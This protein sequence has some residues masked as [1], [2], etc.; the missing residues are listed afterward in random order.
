MKIRGFVFWPWMYE[1]AFDSCLVFWSITTH[2]LHFYNRGKETSKC[3]LIQLRIRCQTTRTRSV[4]TTVPARGGWRT[5]F[6]VRGPR[7]E[8][9][10]QQQPPRPSSSHILTDPEARS[11][12]ISAR[13][14]PVTQWHRQ[15]KSVQRQGTR[16]Y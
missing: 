12:R 8:A 10:P 4:W 5:G 2:L 6:W 14:V 15:L 1:N 3:C 11:R 16:L 7:F 13:A 9:R